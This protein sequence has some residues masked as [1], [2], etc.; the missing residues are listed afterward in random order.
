[1]RVVVQRVLR[2]RVTAGGRLLGSI[3]AG[4]L[5]LVGF[6]PAD[7]ADIVRWMAEKL[8]RLRI[9][10]D[11]EGKMNR[12]VAETGG[13][14]LVVSQFTL[15]ADAGRG[16]RPGFG[17]AAPPAIALPLYEETLRV[18][19]SLHAGPVEAGEFGAS[20]EVELVNDGPVTL[21]LDR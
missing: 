18:L 19:R 12:S 2:A 9:F 20:M 4:L 13:G 8:V 16:N 17:G 10:E 15:Y 6:A 21:L 7:D 1:M 14:I 3:G 11:R 5:V